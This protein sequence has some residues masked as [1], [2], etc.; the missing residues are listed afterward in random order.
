MQSFLHK[1]YRVLKG[2][3]EYSYNLTR[4]RLKAAKPPTVED[5]AEAVV[6]KLA[7]V[8]NVHQPVDFGRE[9]ELNKTGSP[10]LYPKNKVLNNKQPTSNQTPGSQQVNKVNQVLEDKLNRVKNKHYNIAMSN[11]KRPSGVSR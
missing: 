1:L 3:P 2:D 5:A 6:E 4:K 10:T 7:R 8:L 9:V 11:K